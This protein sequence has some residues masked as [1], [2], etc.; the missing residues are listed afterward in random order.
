MC[1]LMK[2]TLEERGQ[3]WPEGSLTTIPQEVEVVNYT[4]WGGEDVQF[5]SRHQTDHHDIVPRMNVISM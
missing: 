3:M 1:I 5:K 2:P 4:F